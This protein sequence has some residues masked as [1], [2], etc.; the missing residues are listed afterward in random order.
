MPNILKIDEKQLILDKV[1]EVNTVDSFQGREKDI[2]IIS[3]VRA[4]GE[5]STI[6]FLSDYR[7]MNVA[8]TRAKHHLFVIGNSKT[9]NQNKNWNK[10]ITHCKQNKRITQYHSKL[11]ME[12][13]P[14]FIIKQNEIN[15]NDVWIEN[16]IPFKAYKRIDIQQLRSVPPKWSKLSNNISTNKR[17]KI[18]ENTENVSSQKTVKTKMKKKVN[19]KKRIQ[20]EANKAGDSN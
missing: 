20:K 3:W 17:V 1:V 7:R 11:E 2:I 6:G 15:K 16:I 12:K 19:S 10:F 4:G 13:S 5:W 14:C 8:L 18:S 9:L